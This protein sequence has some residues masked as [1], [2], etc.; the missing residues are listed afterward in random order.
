MVVFPQKVKHRV[1][2]YPIKPTIMYISKRNENVWLHKTLYMLTAVLFINAPE[3]ETTQMF[4]NWRMDIYIKC[5]ISLQWTLLG[6]IR[7]WSANTDTTWIN[8]ENIMLK[9]TKIQKAR[10][11]IQATRIAS[12]YTKIDIKCFINHNL[13]LIV[14]E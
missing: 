1:T 5:G 10:I 14:T 11:I 3:W 7:K 9:E 8:L 2:I 6:H 13:Q 12:F 4:V